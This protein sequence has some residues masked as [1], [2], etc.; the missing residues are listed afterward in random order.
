MTPTLSKSVLKEF[1]TGL[2]IAVAAVILIA[3]TAHGPAVEAQPQFRTPI[4]CTSAVPITINTITT[5]QLVGLTS[6]QTIHI[7]GFV[8]H[9]AG[10]TSAKLVY[11]TGTNCATGTTDITPLF[12]FTTTPSNVTYGSGIGRVAGAPA[13]NAVCVNNTAAIQV[14]GVLTYAKF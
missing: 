6:G 10:A 5:T 12:T 1:V 14:S 3:V 4:S 13:S 7:C 9:S 11:G 8:L 2:V